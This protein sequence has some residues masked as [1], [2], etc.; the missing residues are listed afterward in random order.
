MTPGDDGEARPGPGRTRRAFLAAGATAG[1]AALA[2]CEGIPFLGGGGIDEYSRW[3]G[4]PGELEGGREM[5]RFNARTPSDIEEHKKEFYP[6]Q[7][8]TYQRSYDTLGLSFQN[9][10]MDL[11]MPD[12]TVL[13]GSF[14]LGAI[15]EELEGETSNAY[16]KAE[17]YRRFEVFVPADADDEVDADHAYAVSDE[18]V[19]RGERIGG[20]FH[21]DVELT[22]PEV[23]TAIV[24]VADGDAE[25]A[26]EEDPAFGDL[27]DELGAA[28][29]VNGETHADAVRETDTASGRFEGEVA[30]GAA[31]SVTGAET[32]VERVA[33][34][35]SADDVDTDAVAEWVENNDTGNGAWAF[36]RNV[37]VEKDGRLV[38]VSGTIDTYDLGR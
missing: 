38:V 27:V 9:V 14:E 36:V 22:A 17:S 19:V 25:R 37:G 29:F 20:G 32:T 6:R 34:F 2:G 12:G 10:T 23:A 7:Y 4:V 8:R 15:V 30:R 16:T 26:H 3:I 24:D 21:R 11:S 1:V 5:V 18:T 35:E 28:T 31:I 33:V 13:T